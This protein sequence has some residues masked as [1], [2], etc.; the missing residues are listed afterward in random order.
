MVALELHKLIIKI[1]DSGCIPDDWRRAV[2][3]PIP[4]PGDKTLVSNY[5]GICIQANAAK[6]YSNILKRRL[7]NWAESTLSG[8]QYG[9][10]PQ[11]SC[12]DAI[13]T[14]PLVE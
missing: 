6:V 9:F 3:I 13:F 2:L 5:R 11:R 4:K 7:Q 12:A 8:I 10:R 1:W 14:L